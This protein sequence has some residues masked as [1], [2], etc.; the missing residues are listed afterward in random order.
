VLITVL[1]ALPLLARIRAEEAFLRAQF[2][3]E[4]DACC[5]RTWRLVPLVF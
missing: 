3:S 1:I 5:A 2:G 4:Y